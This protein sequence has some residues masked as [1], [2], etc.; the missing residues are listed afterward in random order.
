MSSTSEGT[1]SFMPKQENTDS[2]RYKYY[3]THILLP[4]IQDSILVF[5]GIPKYAEDI[6]DKLTSYSWCKGN[7]R[8]VQT[9]VEHTNTYIRMKIVANKHNPARSGID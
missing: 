9:M 6:T 7:I 3:L 1:V 2:I 4:F 5:D 8:E